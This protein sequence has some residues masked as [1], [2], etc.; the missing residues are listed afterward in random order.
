MSITMNPSAII[1]IRKDLPSSPVALVGTHSRSPLVRTRSLMTPVPIA[2]TIIASSTESQ[3]TPLTI[4]PFWPQLRGELRDRENQA[5]DDTVPSGNDDDNHSDS[6]WTQ[7]IC[8]VEIP[9]H[10]STAREWST[11]I[12]RQRTRP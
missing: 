2:L 11:K 10:P 1:A 12:G 5:S 4:C 8:P 7:T 9:S 6:Q 3:W